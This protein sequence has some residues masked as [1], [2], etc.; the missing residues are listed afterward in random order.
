MNTPTSE[1]TT[2]QHCGGTVNR[3][4]Q[5]CKH[6][7]RDLKQPP[8]HPEAPSAA[9]IHG[10]D[11]LVRNQLRKLLVGGGLVSSRAFDDA[12]SQPTH[13]AAAVLSQLSAQRHLTSAQAELQR[14]AFRAAQQRNFED[15]VRACAERGLLNSETAG[16]ARLSF[17]RVLFGRGP[18]A[19]LISE[20]QITEEQSRHLGFLSGDAETLTRGSKISGGVTAGAFKGLLVLAV[21][22]FTM[23]VRTVKLMMKMLREVGTQGAIDTE[24]SDVPHLSWAVTAGVVFVVAAM[25]VAGVF[26]VVYVFS[27]FRQSYDVMGALGT[28]LVRLIGSMLGIVAVNWVLMVLV[29]GLSLTISM[30]NNIKKMADR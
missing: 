22:Y 12:A 11:P 24:S 1:T 13:D 3:A 25:G 4:A 8:A 28:I 21:S 14:E 19:H 27:G 10:H 20:G 23:P 5:L 2:C 30:A 9:H 15:V 16:S 6:C 7:R 29:E 26:G 18:I 17:E